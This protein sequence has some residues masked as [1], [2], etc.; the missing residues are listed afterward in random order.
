[1][2][3]VWHQTI[4]RTNAAFG[5]LCFMKGSM[6]ESIEINIPRDCM[7]V[8]I[9]KMSYLL[10]GSYY[11]LLIRRQ[12]DNQYVRLI[13]CFGFTTSW[14]VTSNCMSI[15]TPIAVNP[16][17]VGILAISKTFPWASLYNAFSPHD[18]LR[19]YRAVNKYNLIYKDIHLSWI[20]RLIHTPI[21]NQIS[22]PLY[23]LYVC[24]LVKFVLFISI[25]LEIL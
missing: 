19:Y 24:N 3:S 23:R 2:L 16:S 6:K 12:Y 14:P 25:Y 20:I 7:S 22:R 11:L 5:D 15:F 21:H 1:M 18:L 17:V 4:T 8:D 10:F 9:V 13:W